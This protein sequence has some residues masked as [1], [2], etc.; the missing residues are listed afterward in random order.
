[1]GVVVPVGE[2]VRSATIVCGFFVLVDENHRL[3]GIAPLLYPVCSAPYDRLSG[4][5]H[6]SARKKSAPPIWMSSRNQRTSEGS[7]SVSTNFCFRKQ[8]MNGMS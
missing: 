8:Q 1:M 3:R 4:N 6:S 5:C 7:G 2:T